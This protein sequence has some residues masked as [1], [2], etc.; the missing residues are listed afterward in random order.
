MDLDGI[1]ESLVRHLVDSQFPQWSS[2]S[3]NPVARQGVDNHTF[4]LGEDL[5]VRMPTGD[6]YAQQVAKEQHWLPK[7]APLLPLPI[8][9]PV[10]EGTP[11]FGYPYRG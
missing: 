11:A 6:W 4:R 8:P 1:D 7:L 2:L 9:E 10:A 5:S 3:I